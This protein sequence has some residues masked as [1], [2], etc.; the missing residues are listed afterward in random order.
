MIGG[1]NLYGVNQAYQ[2]AEMGYSRPIQPQSSVNFGNQS[3]SDG[4]LGSIKD[5]FLTFTDDAV[6]AVGFDA[7][8]AW[9]QNLVSGKLLVGKINKHFTDKITPEE[10]SNLRSLADE[11]LEQHG[12]KDKVAIH[13]NGTKG[14]AFYTHQGNFIKV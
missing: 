11:M 7:A 1:V 14:E 9:L 3:G 5:S 12:L 4:I 2:K 13:T 6:G 8:L 10:Q